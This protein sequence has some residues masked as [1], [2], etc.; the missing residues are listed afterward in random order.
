V[1]VDAMTGEVRTLSAEE[2]AREE[3]IDREA[4]TTAVMEAPTGISPELIFDPYGEEVLDTSK[5]EFE[6]LLEQFSGHSVAEVRISGD[7]SFKR[8]GLTE[9]P[10]DLQL[11]Q[12]LEQEQQ[13]IVLK[14]FPALVDRKTSVDVSLF[15][16]QGEADANHWPGVR[17]LLMLALPQ[18]V[19]WIEKS[20]PQLNQTALLFN[21]LGKKE[22]FVQDLQLA[23]F[24][25]VFKGD[26]GSEG[27]DLPRDAD[28]F[29][30]LL[31][32]RKE[33]IGKEAEALLKLCHRIL[34]LNHEIHKRLKG[35]I[36][37]ALAFIYS[38][39]RFQLEHLVYP[40]FLHQTGP[41]WLEAL[42]RYLEGILIRL[43]KSGINRGRDQLWSQELADLWEKYQ[44]KAE[45]L[46]QREGSANRLLPFRWMLE[47]YRISLFAQQLG[48]AMPVS[49]KRLDKLWSELT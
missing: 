8:Q 39:I 49:A 27:R 42:P 34:K 48:T 5:E 43:D 37:L 44:T 28:A 22:Q 15:D 1:Y 3:A 25:R 38:D 4:L 32:E 40:G 12:V 19:K 20:L 41:E 16:L 36:P 33:L 2:A 9:W 6:E 30:A 11:P 46:K 26:H 21:S 29:A 23:V 14:A 31:N 10:A 7:D 17:R 13:G 47:E 45:Q 35:K 24:D 18:Q